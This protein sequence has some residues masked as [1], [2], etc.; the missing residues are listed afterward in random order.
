L[1]FKSG[2]GMF[3]SVAVVV[4]VA[5]ALHVKLERPAVAF[6]NRKFGGKRKSAEFSPARP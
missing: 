5:V 1:D 3:V 6:L 4:V 2:A